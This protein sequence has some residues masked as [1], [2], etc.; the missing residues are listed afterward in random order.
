M[1]HAER[2][3]PQQRSSK[4]SSRPT[5]ERR[6]S[7]SALGQSQSA[8]VSKKKLHASFESGLNRPA[9]KTFQHFERLEP[10]NGEI[11][12]F[13][14][15]GGEEDNLFEEEICL[16]NIAIDEVSYGDTNSI[17]TDQRHGSYTP[18]L[19]TDEL[20]LFE[21]VSS[22][23]ASATAAAH[24]PNK[25]TKKKPTNDD[26]RVSR[27]SISRQSMERKKPH[28]LA[29]DDD[30]NAAVDD[31]FD[32]RRQLY[33]KGKK[34]SGKTKSTRKKATSSSR[35]VVEDPESKPS[36]KGGESK[37][38]IPSTRSSATQS[39]GEGSVSPNTVMD[40]ITV[41]ADSLRPLPLPGFQV[42]FNEQSLMSAFGEIKFSAKSKVT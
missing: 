15:E 35:K 12:E 21:I 1:D 33:R 14:V 10:I 13:D 19:D 22:H 37:G 23:N 2:L 26:D 39:S 31:G 36:S 17:P 38:E 6:S 28:H 8:P 24:E 41:D 9:P 27:Q 3:R 20:S 25:P 32:T 30:S 40:D 29:S 7:C 42:K 11:D 18:L 16:P 5:L 34:S 4:A